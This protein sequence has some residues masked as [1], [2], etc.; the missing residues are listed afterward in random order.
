MRS[1]WTLPE[2]DAEYSRRMAAIKARF[3]RD[4]RRSGFTPTPPANSYGARGEGESRDGLESRGEP[5]P[6]QG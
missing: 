3:S 4:I 1:V 5:R 2:E 6:T